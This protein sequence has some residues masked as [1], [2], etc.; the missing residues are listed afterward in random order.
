M[1]TPVLDVRVFANRS[2]TLGALCM[3][4]NFGITLAVMY[5]IPQYLQNSLHLAA[6]TAGFLLLPG[7]IINAA[8]SVFSGKL[9]DKLGAAIPCVLGFA[10]SLYAGLIFFMQ[11][12]SATLAWVL[13]AHIMCMIGVPLAM[14]PAQTYVL[15]ALSAKLISDG[16]T[17][18]NTL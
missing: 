9:Y 14:S 11:N 15:S 12:S 13:I 7:G 5:M 1:D 18:L 17:I 2:Y 3:M 10:I 16:S 4:F 6:S 8:V